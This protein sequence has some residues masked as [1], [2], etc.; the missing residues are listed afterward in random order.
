[1]IILDENFPESQRQL[2]RGWHIPLRQIGY[3]VGRKGMQDEELLPFL[4]YRRR[5]TFF[6]LD[7]GFYRRQLCHVRYCLICVDVGQ[8][9]AAAFVRRLL[10]HRQFDTEAKRLALPFAYRSV[11]WGCGVF[12]PRKKSMSIGPVKVPSMVE[13]KVRPHVLGGIP[14]KGS[15]DVCIHRDA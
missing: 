4:R 6:T 2:L 10:R 14:S 8:Y 12:M 9:A 13:D 1:M 7:Q 3:E 5:T 11:G 15:D